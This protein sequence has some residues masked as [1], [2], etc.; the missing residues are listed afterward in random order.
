MTKKPSRLE[1]RLSIQKKM[2]QALRKENEF[3]KREE[4]NNSINYS[5][6]LTEKI[7]ECAF[8]ANTIIG[9][10]KKY[11]EVVFEGIDGTGKTTLMS[12]VFGT[13]NNYSDANIL[14]INDERLTQKKLEN[15][16]ASERVSLFE[17]TTIST[18]L[19]KDEDI[20][21]TM[22]HEFEKE[23]VPG[24]LLKLG[25]ET[26]GSTTNL[27]KTVE[28]HLR[29][30]GRELGLL[31]RAYIEKSRIIKDNKI[32]VYL[33][34]RGLPTLICDYILEV[35]RNND[36]NSVS[37]NKIN[38]EILQSLSY[39]KRA[40]TLPELTI[41]LMLSPKFARANIIKRY[42]NSPET[43]RPE[44]TENIETLT[45]NYEL[46][47]NMTKWYPNSLIIKVEDNGWEGTEDI[48]TRKVIET[49]RL[50]KE[51]DKK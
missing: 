47:E 29:A 38:E 37:D 45:R 35:L 51:G 16:E 32:N 28:N 12:K 14:D 43:K 50:F 17:Q 13:I 6:L 34:E 36:K 2:V 8:D 18:E 5:Q 26:L 9:G 7:K 23:F 25:Y 22:R 48:I 11:F 20:M 10:G 21:R 4:I 31:N 30:S 15:P 19:S 46:L 1:K 24:I 49:Y 3:L 33:K 42:Q 39:F 44:Q 40:Y 27:P 41:F